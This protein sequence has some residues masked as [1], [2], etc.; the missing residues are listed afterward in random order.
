MG[1]DYRMMDADNHYYEQDDCFSRHIEPKFA[2]E[3]VRLITNPH[4]GARRWALGDRLVSFIDMNPADGVLP[5]GAIAGLFAG[6][7]DYSGN[8]AVKRS[9]FDQPA[10]MHRPERLTMMDEQNIESALIIPSMAVLIE[11]DFADRPEVVCA[12][13]RSFNRWLEEEW[14][15]GSDGR[16]YGLPLLTMLDIDWAM[17]E[18]ERVAAL[19]ARMFYL[20]TGP[21]GGRSP[22]DTH[23]DR[24][25]SLVEETGLHPVFHIGD[26]VF[27]HMYAS[28]W[29]EDPNRAHGEFSALQHL[30]C[31]G[32]RP[33][34][35]TLAA[36]V[37]H[38]LFGRHPNLKVLS[39]EHGSSWVGP[40]LKLMDKSAMMGRNGAWPFGRLDAKPS[41]IFREHV[42]LTPYP[43]DDVEK[44]VQVVGPEH[45]L[46]GSDYPHPEGL[47]APDDFLKMLSGLPA[48]DV[49]LIMRENLA[50]LLG[51]AG[52]R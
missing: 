36:L 51:L 27:A 45:V 4:T 43:E 42:Y 52:T 29:G 17:A 50:G 48:D 20:K 19:G 47:E 7:A 12:N 13:Y 2:G 33:I 21:V 22:A 28:H 18:L 6:T 11:G 39:I 16:I 35:D 31:N 15:Y 37:L 25:W 24:F 14:T 32:E 23:F 10:L 8:G 30:L 41:E 40:L 9:A 49:R 26:N 3:A 46:F 34:S 5:P 44:L 38:N 1:L